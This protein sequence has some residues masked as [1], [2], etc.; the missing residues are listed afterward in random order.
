M[1]LFLHFPHHVCMALCLVM[2]N[3]K[4]TCSLKRNL[5]LLKGFC[6]YTAE[7]II[8]DISVVCSFVVWRSF[9][10]DSEYTVANEEVIHE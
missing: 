3:N 9:C 5:N 7:N 4:F 6:A 10:S 2:Y 8:I 1:E